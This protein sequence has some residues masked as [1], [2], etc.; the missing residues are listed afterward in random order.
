MSNAVP[1]HLKFCVCLVALNLGMLNTASGE[2]VVLERDSTL[3]AS[4][5]T[6]DG[7]DVLMFESFTGFGLYDELFAAGPLSASQTSSVS[8]GVFSI[9][10]SVDGANSSVDDIGLTEAISL[11]NVRFQVLAQSDFNLSGNLFSN[12]PADSD[13]ATRLSLTGPDTDL[14]FVSPGLSGSIDVGTT[15]ILTPGVYVLDLRAVSLGGTST[16]P[17]AGVTGGNI[18]LAITSSSIP[19][20]SAVYVISLAVLGP[21]VRRRKTN[22]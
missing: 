18:S 16:D 17:P 22:R 19:E 9:N 6:F 20:P 12:E 21:L 4:D 3:N 10:T 15:G 13:V 1:S 14:L 5:F 7:N 8:G 2:V 11:F